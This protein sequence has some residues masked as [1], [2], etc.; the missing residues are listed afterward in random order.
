MR[1]NLGAGG[2]RIAGYLAVDS[3]GAADVRHDLT[4]F[5]W[6]WDDDSADAI[7]ASHV[8]EHFTRRDGYLF[9][10]ECYRILK[11]YGVLTLSVPDM[12]KFI[13][14]ILAGS[15]DAVGNPH[16]RSLDTLL[17]GDDSELLEHMRHR[18]LYNFDA[19]DGILRRT[20]FRRVERRGF[21]GALDNADHRLISL[22]VR[23]Q[24]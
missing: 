2:Q 8:L 23:A 14:C 20:G 5:P 12:D 24:K 18:H 19:L 9:L 6:P 7:N 21:D 4:A 16:W 10:A 15:Y 3:H 17:G 13:D 22:Y 11:P 1:L